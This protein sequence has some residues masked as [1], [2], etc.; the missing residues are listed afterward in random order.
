[1]NLLSRARAAVA[2]FRNEGNGAVFFR[3]S[4]PRVLE[5][6]GPVPAAAGVYV[7]PETAQRVSAVY[8]CVDRISGGISTLTCRV[9]RRDGA[10]RKEEVN[11]PLWWL[12]N[13]QPCDAWTAASHW[14]RALQY[15]L[16]RGDGFSLIKRNAAGVPVELVP[17]PWESVV[18]ERD[19][20]AVDARNIYMVN[21][22]YRAR[23]YDQDDIL[24]FPGYGFNGVRSMSVLSWGARNATG[25][26]IAMDEYSGKF[27]ADGA[28]PSIVLKTDRLMKQ[29]QIDELQRQFQAKYSGVTNAHKLPLVLTEGLSAQ[30]ISINAQDAQL[31]EAR[32][33]QVVDIARAF[34]VPPHLI[35][36]TSAST[37]WGSGI[38]SM[39]RA[40]VMFTL[41]PHLKRLE[42]ELNRKL[43][44]TA[45]T[46]VEFDRTELMQGDLKTQ[47]EYYRA[48]LG[49]PG[50][51]K[52]WMTPNEVRAKGYME[53]APGGDELF[54][55]NEAQEA[56]EPDGDEIKKAK[57]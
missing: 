21:D 10:V 3:S 5:L 49:G 32:K 26:A 56:T 45:K 17:L 40:F 11:H 42:Q 19:S 24:H 30:D 34:G 31:L 38:E 51:G 15:I 7:T 14:A 8:A 4:D 22:G 54:D 44:R 48:A 39:G 27:F 41:Q 20:L 18:T 35:G 55:P 36:E 53:P 43:F 47:A 29:S 57:A 6:M 13:E 46:F 1:M 50:T 25:N 2:A 28:H 37:S 23:G 12:L 9:Y 33:F 52:G 16:L